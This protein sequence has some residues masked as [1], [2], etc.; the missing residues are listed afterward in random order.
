MLPLPGGAGGSLWW[1]LLFCTLTPSSAHH[2]SMRG[3]RVVGVEPFNQYLQGRVR[4]INVKRTG[5]SL[6]YE[7]FRDEVPEGQVQWFLW[8]AN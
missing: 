5:N 1:V 6:G 4:K 3:V 8:K 7:V 2:G